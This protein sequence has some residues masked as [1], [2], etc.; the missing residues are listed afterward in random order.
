MQLI[1]KKTKKKKKRAHRNQ[2]S[3][4]IKSISFSLRAFWKFAFW[5]LAQ[6]DDSPRFPIGMLSK[7]HRSGFVESFGSATCGPVPS[8]CAETELGAASS[9][10]ILFVLW[11]RSTNSLGASSS[12][13]SSPIRNQPCFA[14]GSHSS[15]F[16]LWPWKNWSQLYQA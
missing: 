6:G 5:L 8:V 9:I 13:R 16:L 2:I 11:S 10:C 4:F 3:C 7:I 15:V 1:P 14:P 12:F